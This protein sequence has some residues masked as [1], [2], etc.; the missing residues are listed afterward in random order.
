[1]LRNLALSAGL[2]ALL[3]ATPAH[4]HHPSGAGTAGGA[5]PIV[6]IP[7]TTL[8]KGRGSAA[9]VFEFIGLNALSDAQLS[10]PGHPHS[11]D[12]IFAPSL[13]YSY[14]ITDDLTLTLRLPFMR[15]TNIREG[16]VH[17]GVGG[18]ASCRWACRS[19]T[20]STGCRL[21]PTGACSRAWGSIFEVSRIGECGPVP[22][23]GAPHNRA[24]V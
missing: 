21:S 23:Q 15:R 20:T 22:L 12:A 1:M 6:T 11:L 18:R 2:T 4:A 9:V 16:H 14:G 13:L 5:G 19:S 17:G 3:L 24:G 10:V 8:E 7:G